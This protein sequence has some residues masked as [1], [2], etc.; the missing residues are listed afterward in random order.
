MPARQS[1]AQETV[2]KDSQDLL[3]KLQKD[4]SSKKISHIS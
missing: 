2:K 4:K 3:F 1:Y